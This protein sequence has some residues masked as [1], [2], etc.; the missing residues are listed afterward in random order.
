VQSVVGLYM[1]P[2]VRG[3]RGK[4]EKSE[5][6]GKLGNLKVPETPECKS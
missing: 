2:M 1:V 5:N 6:Q 4:L 3:S